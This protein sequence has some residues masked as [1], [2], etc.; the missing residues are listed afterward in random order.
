MSAL[1]YVCVSDMHLGAGYSVLTHMDAD[2]EIDLQR[3]SATLQSWA[4][5]LRA[6]VSR[7]SGQELPT[8]VLLGDV[9]DLGQSQFGAVAQGFKRFL[10]AVFPEGEAPVFSSH[11][12]TVPGNHDHH[13]WRTAQD[14]HFLQTLASPRKDGFIPDL[15][16]HTPL[17]EPGDIPCDLMATVMH[18]YP[19]LADATV[20]VAYPNLGLFDAASGRCVVMHHGH[21]V[22]AIYRLM[23]TIS[24]AFGATDDRPKTVS[25]LES[26]NGAW[27][28]F[29]FSSL[30]SAGKVGKDMDTLYA[31]LRDAAASRQFS[32]QLTDVLSARLTASFGLGGDTEITH[33]ITVADILKALTDVTLVRGA[34]SERNGYARVLSDDGVSDLRWYLS[35]PVLRQFDERSKTTGNASPAVHV[36]DVKELSFVFGHTHKPFQD[37]LVVPPYAR[38]VAVYNTG[39]WV[40][41]Q[42]TM[43]ATQGAA[44]VFIDDALNLASLRLFNDPVNGQMPAVHAAG[45]GGFQDQANPLLAKMSAAVATDGELWGTFSAAARAA[46]ELHASVLLKTFFTPDSNA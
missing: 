29:L 32:Q 14:R 35:G 16:Q 24:S 22:D 10:E 11:L 1:K 13:L 17:F 15:L 21:Y 8:L 39:G 27:V 36:R 30:G 37:Q 23:S 46:A 12:I 26:E 25:K 7:C 33:G 6:T 41:D 42:P 45:V 4:K 5:A 20:K 43:A 28:D 38:P 9:L 34:E 31:M 40:M 2:G 44:M 18:T 3:P 19:H